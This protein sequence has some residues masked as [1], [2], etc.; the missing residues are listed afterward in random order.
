MFIKSKNAAQ[1]DDAV[2]FNPQ[3]EGAGLGGNLKEQLDATMGNASADA[4]VDVPTKSEEADTDTGA[5][6]AGETQ[7]APAVGVDP[8]VG[9]PIHAVVISVREFAARIGTEV[10]VK[11]LEDVDATLNAISKWAAIKGIEVEADIAAIKSAHNL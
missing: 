1:K 9:T 10:E 11:T 5:N 2:G 3:Q 4:P 6:T 7:A 8:E